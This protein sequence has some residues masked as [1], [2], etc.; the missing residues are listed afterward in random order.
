M[1]LLCTKAFNTN[2]AVTLSRSQRYKT[3]NRKG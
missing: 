2:V 1:A 3:G